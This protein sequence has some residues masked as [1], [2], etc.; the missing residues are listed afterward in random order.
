VV[1]DVANLPVRRQWQIVRHAD[2]RL[3]PAALALWEFLVRKGSTFLPSRP[4]RARSG[5]GSR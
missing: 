5:R 4:A 1:L 2:K 3:M